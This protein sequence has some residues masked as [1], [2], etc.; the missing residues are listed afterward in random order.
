MT[1]SPPSDSKSFER[2][3]VRIRQW[4]WQQ[5]W[6]TL[7]EV[8]EIAI[9]AILSGT[10]DVIVS[11]PTSAGKTEAAF[12]PILTRM[13]EV[14]LPSIRALYIGPT[15]AL[16]NDQFGRLELLCENLD[17][18]VHKWH[19]DVSSSRKSALIKS[20]RGILLITPESLEAVFMR[21]GPVVRR[22]LAHLSY[23]VVDEVHS[24][25]GTERGAQLRSLLHRIDFEVGPGVRRVGL[26]ATLSDP[27]L[28]GVFLRAKSRGEPKIIVSKG[29]GEIKAQLRAFLSTASTTVSPEENSR[30]LSAKALLVRHYVA[31]MRGHHNL[32][33]C[34][35]KQEVEELVDELSES[36]R[37]LGVQD[38]FM[39]H[40]GNLSKEIRETVEERLRSRE[41][42][43]TCVCTSTLELGIDVGSMRS[44]GQVGAPPSVASL[45]QRVG[46]SGRRGEPSIL[47]LSVVED[48]LSAKST[49][50]DL[51]RLELVQATASV[52]LMAEG[53]CEPPDDRALH[54]STL[55][56]QVLSVLVQRGGAKPAFL[57]GLLVDGGPFSSVGKETFI[58]FLR[59]LKEK[60]LVMQM[61]DGTLLPG[62][63]GERLTEHY[64]FYAAFSTPEEYSLVAD[65]KSIGTLPILVPLKTGDP[66]LFAG[67]RWEVVA[68]DDVR[69]LV[70]LRHSRA[71]RAP[72]FGGEGG[73]VHAGIRTRMR[74]LYERGE[75]PLFL[76]SEAKELF[77]E[78]CQA[79][80]DHGLS[81]TP[82]RETGSG[83]EIYHWSGDREATTLRLIFERYGLVV[84]PFPA[85]LTVDPDAS[86]V[87]RTLQCIAEAPMIRAT[88]L[89]ALAQNKRREKYDWE[90][91]DS[92]MTLEYA[93]RTI[94]VRAAMVLAE[95]LLTKP[96]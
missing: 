83:T 43:A 16:I 9:P 54:L 4:I 81:A 70:T 51:L 84:D 73:A 89:A 27:H 17:V 5:K 38:E 10:D 29:G 74:D 11:A 76:D 49:L 64:G 30:E 1:D 82:V 93:A 46:R 60:D 44:V 80:R 55:V 77:R 57:Y 26:S 66:L 69:R 39:A 67:K 8:Q 59:N 31:A 92:L 63:A 78:A 95:R 79:Y 52:E 35:R 18:P 85:V 90:L 53:W 32:I 71:K 56:Q 20:P 87:R 65:G 50:K 86:T 88:D 96:V 12:L 94:D 68:V 41:R 58:E 40:H 36:C 75:P 22:I 62:A 72:L 42:P 61:D 14:E 19:G 21:Q 6:E 7:R 15:K 28:A 45:R 37:R 34:N 33:F 24:F 3:D 2:L 25:I 13:L 48:E 47:R 23:V 91:T